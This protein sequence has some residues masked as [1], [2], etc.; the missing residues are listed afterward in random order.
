MADKGDL[1]KVEEGAS[2]Y[3]GNFG[4]FGRP[5]I[6]QGEGSEIVRDVTYL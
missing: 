6:A 2:A 3:F 1:R 4:N 5:A